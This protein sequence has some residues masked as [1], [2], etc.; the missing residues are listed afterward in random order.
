[1][2]IY[3]NVLET[4]KEA[5]YTTYF[6]RKNK[7]MGESKIQ[8]IRNN[9]IDIRTVNQICKLLNCNPGDILDYIPDDPTKEFDNDH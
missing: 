8:N 7:I 3:K 2:I 1:M 6:M 5:G 4:L 9:N